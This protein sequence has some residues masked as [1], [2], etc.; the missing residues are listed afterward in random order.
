MSNGLRAVS[1][2]YDTRTMAH[3]HKVTGVCITIISVRETDAGIII[4]D[5]WDDTWGLSL[6]TCVTL[7][8]GVTHCDKVFVMCVTC[9]M[10]VMFVP[11]CEPLITARVSWLERARVT[12]SES[13]GKYWT[14]ASIMPQYRDI[15]IITGEISSKEAMRTLDVRPR[16]ADDANRAG[17]VMPRCC[18]QNTAINIPIMPW[19]A[20]DTGP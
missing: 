2:H 6:N 7:W 14:N 16:T 8:G 19:R 10:L 5:G 1:S 3:G 4:T 11:P 15:T 12:T 9:V 20:R 17:W 13:P 18:V